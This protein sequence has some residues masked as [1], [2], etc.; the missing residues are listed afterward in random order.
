[1]AEAFGIFAGAAG[2]AGLFVPCVDCFEYIQFGRRFGKDYEACLVKLDVVRLR[3]SR[4]GVAVGLLVDSTEPR[5]FFSSRRATDTEV[6]LVALIL[7]QIKDAFDEVETTS[8][9]LRMKAKQLNSAELEIWDPN[10]DLAPRF[11]SIHFKTRAMALRRQNRTNFFQKA[12]WALYEKKK[13]DRLI[14]DVTGFV[15]S[16]EKEFPGAEKRQKALCEHEVSEISDGD[17]L[18]LLGDIAGCDDTLL[19]EAIT[20][21]LA[22]RGTIYR[23]FEINGEETAK[24]HVGKTFAAV[25]P[26]GGQGDTF[27]GFKIYGKGYTHVGNEYGIRHI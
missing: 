15:D 24:T 12:A 11:Q 22:A 10:T 9:M 6:E 3:L 1:M 26:Q 16:L 27:E 19:T 25:E 7:G 14:E 18:K 13:F 20:A 2:L 5:P 21:T 23:N 8:N 17:S 4:W